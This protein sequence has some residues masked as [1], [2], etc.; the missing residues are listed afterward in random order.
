MVG[1]KKMGIYKYTQPRAVLVVQTLWLKILWVFLAMENAHGMFWFCLLI[2]CPVMQVNIAVSVSGWLG[3]YMCFF[4]NNIS[5]KAWSYCQEPS[6]AFLLSSVFAIHFVTQIL[7]HFSRSYSKNTPK[8]LKCKLF[9]KYI[10]HL[11]MVFYSS[12]LGYRGLG[13]HT[14]RQC[15]NYWNFVEISNRR[16]TQHKRKWKTT[17][18]FLPNLVH[19]HQ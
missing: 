14:S 3:M 18:R 13:I 6:K 12:C 10:Y 11:K 7:Y 8:A 4:G 2:L 17:V 19:D 1:E 9:K 15:V 16:S 5:G